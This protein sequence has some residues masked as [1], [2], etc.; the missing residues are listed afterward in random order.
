MRLLRYASR[1]SQRQTSVAISTTDC[2]IVAASERAREIVWLRRLLSAMTSINGKPELL[3]D[4]VV[5]RNA[6][7]LSPHSVVTLHVDKCQSIAAK[8]IK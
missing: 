5:E 7:S 3:V 2:K 4:N 1:L 6:L 8:Y